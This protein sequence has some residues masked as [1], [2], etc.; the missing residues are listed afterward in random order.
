MDKKM[1]YLEELISVGHVFKKAE[2]LGGDASLP[3]V[4]WEP[5]KSNGV[6]KKHVV[7]R[8]KRGEKSRAMY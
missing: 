6:H 7:A 8:K 1:A 2:W 4:D 3:H 5:K